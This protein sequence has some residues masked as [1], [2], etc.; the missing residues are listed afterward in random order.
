MASYKLLEKYGYS[1]SDKSNM[2]QDMELEYARRLN[3][4]SSVIT[5]MHPTLL[6]KK[7][8][9]YTNYNIFFVQTNHVNELLRTINRY[10]RKILEISRKLPT[11]AEDSF[12]H[13]L[14]VNEIEFSNE[15]EGVKTNRQELSTIVGDTLP[16]NIKKTRMVST[17]KMY[18][19]TLTA[20]PRKI[21]DLNDIKS[22]YDDL[23]DGEIPKKDLPDGKLFRNG[24]ETWIGTSDQIVHR[25][26]KTE[27]DIEIALT[28]MID[29]MNRDDVDPILKSIVTHFMF[30]NTHPFYDGNGRTGR[31]LLSSYISSKLDVY[32]GTSISTAIHENLSK[33]YKAFKE[34]GKQ[35][36]RADLTF[37]IEE[38]LEIIIYGQRTV[39]DALSE[40]LKLLDD[41]YHRLIDNDLGLNEVE[42][43]ILFLLLQS[44]LFVDRVMPPITD[45]EVIDVLNSGKDPIPK[46]RT[47][48]NISN[49]TDKNIL[50]VTKGRPL[51]HQI[52]YDVLDI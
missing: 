46:L 39:I 35:Q 49:L 38:M 31:Y 1:L 22:I 15:I 24:K 23:L 32:T 37:F 9:Q 34:T 28:P 42:N 21:F 25:P 16:N 4:Y 27:S 45:N 14:I 30:E 18:K 36:N 13:N 52:N 41:A 29:F 7:N 20:K 11:V 40:K 44:E 3:D 19:A 33:Y 8:V 43:S 48:N 17:A 5:S 2:T 6:D 26:P 12:I 47:K 51:M 50:I 10:S